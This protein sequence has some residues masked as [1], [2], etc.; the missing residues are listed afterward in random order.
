MPFA[1]FK[2]NESEPPELGAAEAVVES[3]AAELGA[4]EAVVELAADASSSDE[5][6][7]AAANVAMAARERP[8]PTV[9]SEVLRSM[10]ILMCGADRFTGL[11]M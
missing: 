10:T 2:T 3:A 4:A 5:L 7:H 1:V 8:K 6:L 9:R 11:Y